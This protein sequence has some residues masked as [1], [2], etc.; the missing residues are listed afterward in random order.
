MDQIILIGAG[1]HCKACID[2]IGTKGK[3]EIA[4]ILDL[5]VHIGKKVLDYPITGCD[6]DIETLSKTG[7]G[8]FITIGQIKNGSKRAE[9]FDRLERANAEIV[10][11]VSPSASVSKYA[12][13][14]KGT[15]IMHLAM[16]NACASIGQN[17]IINTGANVEHDVVIGDH[18]HISTNA[19]INGDCVIGSYVFVGSNSVV[20]NGV[21]IADGTIIGAG[22][23]VH[24]DISVPGVYAGNPAKKLN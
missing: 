17:V 23:V 18:T 7:I 8:F 11:V 19:V 4:G 3:Y 24:R 2:V 13:I 16:V 20:L 1:G 14:G 21:S 6:D 12:S 10:S 9:L 22:S 15:I 5:P